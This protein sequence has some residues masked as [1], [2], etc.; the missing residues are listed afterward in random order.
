MAR[1]DRICGA[2]S[3][4]VIVL[5]L[6]LGGTRADDSATKEATYAAVQEFLGAFAAAHGSVSCTELLGFNLGDP[7]EA[8]A[9]RAGGAVP[10]VCPGMVRSAGVILKQVLA[11]RA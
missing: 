10:R 8:A 3:G 1:T 5:G 11:R 9:A 2:V 6:A 7:V 4:G